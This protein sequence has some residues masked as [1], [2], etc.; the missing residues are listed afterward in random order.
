[1]TDSSNGSQSGAQQPP[2]GRPRPQFGEYA[3]PGWSWQPPTDAPAGHNGE[4]DAETPFGEKS[5]AGLDGTPQST[6]TVVPQD[7]AVPAKTTPPPAAAPASTGHDAASD[8]AGVSLRP[9]NRV[10]FL[11][12]IFLLVISIWGVRSMVGTTDSM[13][14]IFQTI[15]DQYGLGEFTDADA[16]SGAILFGRISQF[17][18]WTLTVV[19]TIMMLRKR[20]RAFYIP[21]I[22]GAL[23]FL[24]ALI[25]STVALI[26]DPTVMDH[27]S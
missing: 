25:V 13:P 26:N 23:G 3:P 20:R 10:D 21:L 2:A 5:S 17:I 8:K 11:V 14:L 18:L 27:L 22:G 7:S 1:M 19:V 24:L 16:L 12:T 15:Y 6:P 4:V 9:R